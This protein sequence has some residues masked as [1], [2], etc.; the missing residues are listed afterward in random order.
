VAAQPD[1]AEAH[2]LRGDALRALERWEAAVDA[3]TRARSLD[4]LLAYDASFGFR[5]AFGLAHLGRTAEA[6]EEYRR[7]LSATGP[8]QRLRA[9]VFS[10]A[11]DLLMS[12]GPERLD[13]AISF[14]RS[15]LAEGP[16][17]P[18]RWGLA[19]ALDRA[20]RDAEKAP[21]LEHL[22]RFDP[23]MTTLSDEDALFVP[24]EDRHAYQALGFEAFGDPVRAELEW[25]AF[26]DAGGGA[27]PWADSAQ[28]HLLS[29]RT[30]AA[31]APASRTP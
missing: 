21:L 23:R 15:A 2:R 13:E 1:R 24:P 18:A 25:Q 19:L 6:L 12:L 29:L 26:L 11:A 27:G 9:A 8:G 10:N 28:G 5:V 14:Y 17:L 16:S 30:R 31:R 4:P 22:R 7:L 3:W 20:G